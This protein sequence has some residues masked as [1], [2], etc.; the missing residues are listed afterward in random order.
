[1]AILLLLLYC[2]VCLAN[3]LLSKKKPFLVLKKLFLQRVSL[4]LKINAIICS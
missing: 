4:P 2:L 1:M 3:A